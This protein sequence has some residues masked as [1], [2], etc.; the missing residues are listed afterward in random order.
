MALA[1]ETGQQIQAGDK[2]VD[3]VGAEEPAL[4]TG[5][6][7]LVSS[8]STLKADPKSI[9]RDQDFNLLLPLMF[10]SCCSLHKPSY[11]M[12]VC[13]SRDSLSCSDHLK[14]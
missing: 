1:I 8:S 14:E 6:H 5:H 2:Q 4:S 9:P 11:A 12:F 3:W 7:L 10:S 13:K